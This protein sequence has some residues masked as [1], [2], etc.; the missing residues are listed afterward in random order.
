MENLE[1]FFQ[2]YKKLHTLPFSDY[3]DIEIEDAFFTCPQCGRAVWFRDLTSTARK[4]VL[5]EN[6]CPLCDDHF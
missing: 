4:K 5:D 6:W 3:E 2:Q 1:K